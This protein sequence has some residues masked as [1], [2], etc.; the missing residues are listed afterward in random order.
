VR[1]I[2][3]GRGDCARTGCTPVVR[4][5]HSHARDISRAAAVGPPGTLFELSAN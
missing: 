1:Y 2:L 3:L 4:W 5:A